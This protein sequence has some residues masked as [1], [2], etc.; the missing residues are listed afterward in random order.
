[1]MIPQCIRNQILSLIDE[2]VKLMRECK[3]RELTQV[4][5]KMMGMSSTVLL[6][7]VFE[8]AGH[9]IGEYL[10]SQQP[11]VW[12]EQLEKDVALI[13]KEAGFRL[14]AGEFEFSIRDWMNNC[15]F[16]RTPIKFLQTLP[17]SNTLWCLVVAHDLRFLPNPCLS[18]M[19]TNQVPNFIFGGT[20]FDAQ[21]K[22]GTEARE[23]N[24][25]KFLSREKLAYIAMLVKRG[26]RSSWFL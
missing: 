9:T 23:Q 2:E 26:L 18:A 12:W 13:L 14:V 22:K 8:R 1:M 20:S 16:M 4:H 3:Q 15:G 17:E 10:Q 6:L 7:E 21:V 5:Q 19:E 25:P 11:D 24:M